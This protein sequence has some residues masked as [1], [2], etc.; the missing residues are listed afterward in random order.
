MEEN[1]KK[2]RLG[3]EMA[4]LSEGERGRQLREGIREGTSKTSMLEHDK[5]GYLDQDNATHLD[6][7]MQYHTTDETVGDKHATDTEA[8]S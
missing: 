3:H 8:L 1:A 7:S 2:K 6:E 5:L 4:P